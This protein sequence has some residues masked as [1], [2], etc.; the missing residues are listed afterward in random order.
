MLVPVE[1]PASWRP[2]VRLLIFPIDRIR[3]EPLL[4]NPQQWI[5]PAGSPR[6]SGG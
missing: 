6:R 1:R 5:G 4:T 3:T 2:S